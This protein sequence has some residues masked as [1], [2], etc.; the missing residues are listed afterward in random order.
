[1]ASKHHQELEGNT[2]PKRNPL[3]N[4]KDV[5]LPNRSEGERK[6]RNKKDEKRIQTLEVLQYNVQR[7]QG[8]FKWILKGSQQR[9]KP[10]KRFVK[11]EG[12]NIRTY[13]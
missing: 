1:M 10:E 2:G 8:V 4:D 11:G 9:Q 12:V 3:N 6:E 7:R 13:V 5:W